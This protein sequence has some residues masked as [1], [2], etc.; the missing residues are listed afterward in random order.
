MPEG[1][2]AVV[3]QWGTLMTCH[4]WFLHVNGGDNVSCCAVWFDHG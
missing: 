4:Y 2:D 1:M 3:L